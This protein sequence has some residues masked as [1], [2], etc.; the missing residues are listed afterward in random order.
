MVKLIGRIQ[1]EHL[2][3]LRAARRDWCSESCDIIDDEDEN[4]FAN[5]QRSRDLRGRSD[6]NGEF[7][8]TKS[9]R[10][11][12]LKI[13]NLVILIDS[14]QMFFRNF[15]LRHV[16]AALGLAI[17]LAAP[18]ARQKMIARFARPVEWLRSR[19]RPQGPKTSI[20][21]QS[22][23]AVGTADAGGEMNAGDRVRIFHSGEIG[24]V[25][26]VGGGFVVVLL[27]KPRADGAERVRI[28]NKGVAIAAMRASASENSQDLWNGCDRGS[29]GRFQ[30]RQ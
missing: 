3:E 24:K 4:Q 17:G 9:D 23:E 12:D 13:M 29:A 11:G 5:G 19:L 26:Q 2:S 22:S 10:A 1:T 14:A 7:A 8:Q 20:R 6:A 21:V 25:E 28:L 27:D 16:N 30:K 15:G 18:N